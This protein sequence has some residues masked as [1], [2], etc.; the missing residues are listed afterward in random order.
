MPPSTSR[1]SFLVH[2]ASQLAALSLGSTFPWSDRPIARAA[3]ST[4][5]PVRFSADLEPLV[6]LIEDTPRDRAVE[7]IADQFRHGLSYRTLISALFLAGIRNV[8]PQPPGFKFHCVFVIHSAHQISLEAPREEQLWPLFYALDLFK[9]SQAD[10]LRQGDFV[11]RELQG[12]LPSA[13][14]ASSEF[15]AAMEAWDA[16]RADRAIVTLARTRGANEVI[17]LL[18]RYGARD[19]RNIGHKA[20]YV[21]SAW[22][23]LQTIGWQHAEP[24]LRSLVLGILDFGPDKK[25]NQ[26]AFE[27][28]S[29]LPNLELARNSLANLPPNWAGS[30]PENAVTLELL[31]MLRQGQTREAC[32]KSVELLASGRCQT[33]AVWDAAH[34][35]AGELMMSSPGIF[36]I[37]T[38]T[39]INALRYAFDASASQETRLLLLLQGIGW[40]GQFHQ[41]MTSP[42]GK[43]RGKFQPADITTISP[44]EIPSTDE[45][46]AAAIFEKLPDNASDAAMMAFA[47]AQRNPAPA[48][49]FAAACQHIARKADEAHQYKYPAA[50]FEDYRLVSPAWQPHLL[51][52]S[53]YYL[54]GDGDANSSVIQRATAALTA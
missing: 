38:V 23:T 12:E 19:Y 5:G 39:S 26:F 45:A 37:H 24:V 31:A 49:F 46:T 4:P 29:Y 20:I 17:E 6:R 1:R 30:T 10:D 27:D 35:I 41:L 16:E 8:N 15:H 50:I 48:P 40:M 28:Q 7:V 14:V 43:A 33:A 25:V 21:S 52:A 9:A 36:G 32:E 2:S 51:A 53:V 11:L 13:E 47:L 22:R 54:R 3:D 34:L 44:A 42:E 18:W